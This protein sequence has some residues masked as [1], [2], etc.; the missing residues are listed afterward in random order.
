[1][2]Q[3]P[4]T[5]AERIASA[6]TVTTPTPIPAGPH[7]EAMAAQE[8]LEAARADFRARLAAAAQKVVS[9]DG[10]VN[11][12]LMVGGTWLYDR[13]RYHAGVGAWLSPGGLIVYS[14]DVQARMAMPSEAVKLYAFLL[15]EGDA[16]VA[17]EL[18][19]QKPTTP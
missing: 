19:A 11:A 13:W 12:G 15:E 8:A 16:A 10:T 9:V 18:A 14:E 6:Q 5:P 3:S 4:Q 2:T 7:V 1:M 17:A